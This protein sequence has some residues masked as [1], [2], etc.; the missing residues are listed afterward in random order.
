MRVAFIA[1]A[2][3]F[4][5]TP[6]LA[7]PMTPDKIRSEVIGK[8]FTYVQGKF[9]GS[10]IYNPDGTASVLSNESK[11]SDTGKWVLKGNQFCVAWTKIRDGKEA[12]NTF[13]TAG[14]KKFKTSADAVLTVE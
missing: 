5:A 11:I 13:E 4:F 14:S 10:G 8:K 3:A 6:A 7:A 12:C 2:V 9:T 1:F